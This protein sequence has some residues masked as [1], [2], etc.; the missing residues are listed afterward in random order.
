MASSL[1]WVDEKKLVVSGGY[2]AKSGDQ[3]LHFG[4]FPDITALLEVQQIAEIL[5]IQES[6]IVPI[7]HMPDWVMGVYNWR[8]EILW[9]ADLGKLIGLPPIYQHGINRTHYSIL[10]LHDDLGKK[11][12]HRQLSQVS[13]RKLIG[14]AVAKV[15]GMEWCN[16]DH[17]QSP[18][19]YA[20][21]PE[22]SP[23]L[24]GYLIKENGD[25]KVVLNGMSILTQMPQLHHNP[26]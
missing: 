16:P 6:Q 9:L 26:A 3:F 17:I 11:R 10:V 1:S 13:G 24:R 7:P 8:G 15:E 22:L 20:V 4:L 18:P 14:L 25:F 12:G 19:G 21:T 2:R 23:Y 5:T